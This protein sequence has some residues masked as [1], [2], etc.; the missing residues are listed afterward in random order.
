MKVEK[1]TPRLQTTPPGFERPRLAPCAEI[2]PHEAALGAHSRVAR[3]RGARRDREQL[4]L[5]LVV[6]PSL[7][8]DAA[9]LE[10]QVLLGRLG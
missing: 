5:G 1:L 3:Q 9:S 10:T 4:A 8:E 2:Q 7:D 6:R